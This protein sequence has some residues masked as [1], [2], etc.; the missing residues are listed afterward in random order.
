MPIK[1]DF[2]T[3]TDK[4]GVVF[5]ININTIRGYVA[6]DAGSTV[7]VNT[8]GNKDNHINVQESPSTIDSKI[9]SSGGL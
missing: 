3:L 7:Y 2:I 6:K 5:T 8:A 1:S 9:Q 4:Y